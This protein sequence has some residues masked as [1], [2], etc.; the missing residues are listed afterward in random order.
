MRRWT[1]AIAVA[2]LA[3]TAAGV[4][5]AT[6]AH[7]AVSVTDGFEGNPYARWGVVQRQPKAMVYLGNH[8]DP[9]AG[10]SMAFLHAIDDVYAQIFTLN[11]IVLER[12]GPGRPI[13]GANALIALAPPALDRPATRVATV[14]LRLWSGTARNVPP[15]S[16]SVH[17]ITH[18]FPYELYQFGS[19]AFQTTPIYL[20]ISATNGIVLFDDVHIACV[21]PP[22]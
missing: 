3:L 20:E 17:T 5:L 2:A 6:P 1:A 8:Q 16:Q 4:R 19:F 13:C 22:S 10:E 15:L 11:G 12:P 7:A 14:Y 21:E 9:H 18:G